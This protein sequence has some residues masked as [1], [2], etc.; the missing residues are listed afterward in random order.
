MTVGPTSDDRTGRFVLTEQPC[1]RGV[2][3]A[4][5][6]TTFSTVGLTRTDSGLSALH[7]ISARG[8]MTTAARQPRHLAADGRRRSAMLDRVLPRES[9]GQPNQADS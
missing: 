2:A 7:P 3:A 5:R 8:L 1:H 4:I 6:E 9:S